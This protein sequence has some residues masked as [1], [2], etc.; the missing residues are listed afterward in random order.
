VSVILDA[1]RRRRRGPSTRSALNVPA[2]LGLTASPPK[3]SRNG[4]QRLKVIG[5]GAVVVLA[6]LW[7]VMR[8]MTGNGANPALTPAPAI[9]SQLDPAS[10]RVSPDPEPTTAPTGTSTTAETEPAPSRPRPATPRAQLA[11]Q[12]VESRTPDPEPRTPNPDSVDHFAL[13]LRYQNLGDFVRAHEHYLDALSENEFNVEAHNNLGLLYHGRGMTDNAVDQ[14]RRAI[15]INAGY[16][17]ARSNLAV[18]LTS[19]GRLAEARAELRAALA[20]APRDVDLLVNMALVEKADH[21]PEQAIELLVRAVGTAPEHAAAHYNLAVAYEQ[22]DS[23]AL[24][25]DHYNAFLRYAGPEHRSSLTDVQQRIR[26]LEPR[27]QHATN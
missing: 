11:A 19:A 1:L 26:I 17:K 25:L 8:A 6:T 21:H 13:A 15:A 4:H 5:A 23:L 9:A 16:I 2:G 20:L 14:F 27:L 7:V 3:G 18:V 10:T 24:A 22:R 12:A